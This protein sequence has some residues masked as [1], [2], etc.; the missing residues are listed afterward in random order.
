MDTSVIG[1]DIFRRVSMEQRFSCCHWPPDPSP[2]RM[3]RESSIVEEWIPLWRENRMIERL[4]D[5]DGA[6]SRWL[7]QGSSARGCA[8]PPGED[9][10][11][12]LICSLLVGLWCHDSPEELNEN[13]DRL[14]SI[15]HEDPKSEGGECGHGDC[16]CP[17]PD[18]S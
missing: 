3:I 8:C 18:P 1:Q 9:G 7:R 15:T 4:N 12:A 2:K 14:T 5:V 11:S 16:H 6:M 13:I 17:L 10:A